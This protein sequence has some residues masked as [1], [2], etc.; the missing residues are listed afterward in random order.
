MTYVMPTSTPRVQ[1]H[2]QR[3]A[4]G[5]AIYQL[6]LDSAA[7][8]LMLMD[9]G[10]SVTDL[11]RHAC[12]YAS[13]PPTHDRCGIGRIFSLKRVTSRPS[14]RCYGPAESEWI[15]MTVAQ[16]L[17]QISADTETRTWKGD[18][19][20]LAFMLLKH[21]AAFEANAH[22]EEEKA[23]VRVRGILKSAVSGATIGDWAAIADYQNIQEAF[24]QSLRDA[25][26]F[27]AVLNGGMVRAPLRSRGFSITT[28]IQRL[29]RAGRQRQT[30]QLARAW[31]A[32]VRAAEKQRDCRRQQRAGELPRCA[33]NVRHRIAESRRRRDRHKFS[34]CTGCCYHANGIGR[35]HI[36]KHRLLILACCC[37]LSPHLQ[38]VAC[39][40]V[41]SATNM[42]KLVLK[43][44]K[45]RLAGIP[46]IWASWA[47]KSFLALLRLQ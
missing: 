14:T 1:R 13:S 2:R 34:R 40:C 42:K 18:F 33:A 44:N 32:I 28:G 23:S 11:R 41:M 24:Q 15:K 16:R 6:T 21:G 26:V 7:L 45:Y 29:S 12:R 46:R 38:R 31:H 35:Q 39:S 5:K 10:F 36:G 19:T 20:K 43:A 47:A 27:D 22:C 30:S 37:L 3:E 17:G 25:S 9:F 8:E 4:D